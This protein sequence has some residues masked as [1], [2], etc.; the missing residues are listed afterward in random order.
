MIKMKYVWILGVL[1]ALVFV[2][3]QKY[4]YSANEYRVDYLL[5]SYL[6]EEQANINEK[7]RLIMKTITDNNLN[8]DEYL[9]ID[10][11]ISD[12][13]ADKISK[14]NLLKD[15]KNLPT[16]VTD[17]KIDNENQEDENKLEIVKE[18]GDS[19]G[20]NIKMIDE[21]KENSIKKKN[22][23]TRTIKKINRAE[24]RENANYLT[25]EDL[26]GIKN[27]NEWR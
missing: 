11:L 24:G 2:V 1:G 6:K 3:T 21:F 18:S 14:E 4:N 15:L 16:K 5:T 10:K 20:E 7:H 17:K 27:R 26:L 12:Y 19:W 23:M 8:R 9:I 25:D 22:L 13:L